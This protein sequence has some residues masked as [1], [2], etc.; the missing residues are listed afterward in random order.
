MSSSVAPMSTKSRNGINSTMSAIVRPV[1]KMIDAQSGLQ[2]SNPIRFM[3]CFNS[4]LGA[5]N[6]VEECDDAGASIICIIRLS[7]NIFTTLSLNQSKPRTPTMPVTDLPTVTNAATSSNCLCSLLKRTR[8]RLPESP[9]NIGFAESVE[10]SSSLS[11]TARGLPGISNS[12]FVGE[13]VSTCNATKRPGLDSIPTI[14][15]NGMPSGEVIALIGKAEAGYTLPTT[16][17]KSTKA[18]SRIPF[19]L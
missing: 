16:L 11:S 13:P 5:I 3:P 17:A 7:N 6:V 1:S 9:R 12:R 14:T 19:M 10:S 4:K 2:M 18:K 8:T 15:A